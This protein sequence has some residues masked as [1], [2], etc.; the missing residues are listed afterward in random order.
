MRQTRWTALLYALDNE[1]MEVFAKAL[2][3]RNWNVLAIGSTYQY[4]KD[5]EL[6]VEKFAGSNIVENA[7]DHFGELIYLNDGQLIPTSKLL[8]AIQANKDKPED[9][10]ALLEQGIFQIDLVCAEGIN[11]TKLMLCPVGKLLA[12]C[13]DEL[14][15][16]IVALLSAAVKG[17]K[18]IICQ[19]EVR[20]TVMN[21][22]TISGLYGCDRDRAKLIAHACEY[23]ASQLQAITNLWVRTS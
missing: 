19:K 7:A 23:I 3:E 15:P 12:D 22:V 2:L 18:L 6:C 20:P 16:G 4:L 13:I 1:G 10:A 11:Q 5:R 17:N 21:W 8:M 14:N 9:A